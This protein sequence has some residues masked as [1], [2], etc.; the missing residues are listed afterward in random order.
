MKYRQFSTIPNI[1]FELLFLHSHCHSCVGNC[2]ASCIE[3]LW[4][5]YLVYVISVLLN[6]NLSSDTKVERVRGKTSQSGV[7]VLSLVGDWRD[8]ED[9]ASGQHLQSASKTALIVPWREHATISD[10]ALPVTVSVSRVWNSSSPLRLSV[11]LLQTIF[12][13]WCRLNLAAVFL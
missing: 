9:V 10:G 8:D 2:C 3:H 11:L 6:I 4:C 7:Q 1:A 12:F 5:L 13:C